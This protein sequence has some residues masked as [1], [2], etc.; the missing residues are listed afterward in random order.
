[1]IPSRYASSSLVLGSNRRRS[2]FALI[3]AIFFM[4]LLMI[5]FMAAQ[6]AVMVSMRAIQ[7]SGDRIVSAEVD[8]R[9][10]AAALADLKAGKTSNA[11]APVEIELRGGRKVVQTF[12][13]LA[14]DDG[15]YRLLPGITHRNGDA[16]VTI[17]ANEGEGG[18]RRRY[19]INGAGRRS[20]AI[21][22]P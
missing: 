6:S 9:L 16:S 5:F 10:L 15:V 18:G 21:A 11:G 3:F 20:G 19:L 8:S 1:M 7:R 13:L 22:I 17:E 2:G 12:D 4:A 14:A